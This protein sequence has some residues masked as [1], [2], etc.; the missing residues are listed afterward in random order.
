MA[1]QPVPPIDPALPDFPGPNTPEAQYDD[2]AYNWG[3]AIPGYGNRVKAIGDNVFNNANAAASILELCEDAQRLTEMAR[4]TAMG[5][6]NFKGDWVNLSGPLSRP[7]TVQH[8]NSVWLLMRDVANVAAEVPGVSTAWVNQTAR[9]SSVNGRTGDVVGLVEASG[10]TYTKAT[11]MSAAPIGWATFAD[12]TGAGTDWPTTLASSCWNVFTYGTS[13]RKTQRASQVLAGGQQ[14]WVFERQL[15]DST[16]SPW[17]RLFS[18]RALIEFHALFEARSATTNIS[19]SNGSIQTI[20]LYQNTSIVMPAP[21]DIGDQL[22]L[23]IIPT[24]AFSASFSGTPIRL[25]IGA[26]LPTVGPFQRLTLTF[27]PRYDGA[28]WDAFIGGVHES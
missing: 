23:R 14:G 26:S 6:A 9:V 24:G 16:W 15:Q 12:A 13:I 18:D 27:V 8:N 21:R 10:P 4:D 25:P 1:I 20:T 5:V 19:F 7:A 28:V 22:T 11:P 2:A 17:Q 3:S